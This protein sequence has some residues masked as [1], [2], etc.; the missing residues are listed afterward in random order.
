MKYY[1]NQLFRANVN[2]TAYNAYYAGNNAVHSAACYRHCM[3]E[4]ASYQFITVNGVS[5]QK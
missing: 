1:A 2:E 5:A 3:T 4:D